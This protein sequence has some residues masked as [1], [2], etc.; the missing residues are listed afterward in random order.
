MTAL[1]EANVT[2]PEEVTGRSAVRLLVSDLAAAGP[3]A[4]RR[5]A[6]WFAVGIGVTR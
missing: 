1:R 6:A 2:A 4:V 5:D 3:P